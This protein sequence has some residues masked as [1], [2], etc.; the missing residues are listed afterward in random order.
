M[1]P[2]VVDKAA[3]SVKARS[4]RRSERCLGSEVGSKGSEVGAV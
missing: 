4:R 3:M 1:K 2:V